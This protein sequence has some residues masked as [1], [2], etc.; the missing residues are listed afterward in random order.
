MSNLL[1]KILLFEYIMIMFSSI[2]EGRYIFALYWFGAV[3]LN[4]SVLIGM[5]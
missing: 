3:V 1:V 2:I 4:Y 5:K